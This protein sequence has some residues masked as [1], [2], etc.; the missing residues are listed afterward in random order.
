QLRPPL[1]ERRFVDRGLG[2]E[3]L[4]CVDQTV[5]RIL[6]GGV[7]EGPGAEVVA[8]GGGAVR[9]RQPAGDQRALGADGLRQAGDVLHR[10][11]E[12]RRAPFGGRIGEDPLWV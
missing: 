1:P 9:R 10:R 3:P 12:E 8:P 2:G 11:R 6:R 5:A 4:G 7:R